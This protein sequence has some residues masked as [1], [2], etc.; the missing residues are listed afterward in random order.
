MVLTEID[1]M[2][3]AFND[4]VYSKYLAEKFDKEATK[5][6]PTAV[7]DDRKPVISALSKDDDK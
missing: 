1:I 4:P 6:A 5:T 7:P 2:K 3:R